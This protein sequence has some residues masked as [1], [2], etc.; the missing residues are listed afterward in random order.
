MI[1]ARPIIQ[2]LETNF[3]IE[4][5]EVPKNI[6]QVIGNDSPALQD[7]DP[8]IQLSVT[9]PPVQVIEAEE[10]KQSIKASVEQVVILQPSSVGPQGPPGLPGDLI[11]TDHLAG[12]ALGGH[13]GVIV[14]SDN[15]VYYGD[16]SNP[17]HF[18]RVLGISTGA[19]AQDDQASVR[20]GGV[21]TEPS[22]NWDLD[23]F[24]YLGSN[25]LL[26]QTPPGSGFLLEMGWPINPT[27]MMVDI[28]LPVRFW[29]R[30]EPWLRNF[31]ECW[32]A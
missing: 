6:I 5:G 8:V 3:L 2:V 23:K 13:R 27:S 12:E 31:S 10:I 24:I 20:V 16:Q 14:G 29:H 4:I 7:P 32:R 15:K 22:W 19:A 11:V 30:R 28:K 18:N 17:A 26:T 9:P 1:E 25:G 21:M